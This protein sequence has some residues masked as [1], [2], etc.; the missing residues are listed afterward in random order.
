MHEDH[1][2]EKIRALTEQD[3]SL[4]IA[5]CRCE[6]APGW[7]ASMGRHARLG[8]PAYLAATY[9]G[10]RAEVLT[11]WFAMYNQG[12]RTPREAAR[13]LDRPGDAAGQG[14]SADIL[15]ALDRFAS[16]EQTPQVIYGERCPAEV[17]RQAC[18]TSRAA[19]KR[20]EM[21]A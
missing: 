8:T 16:A 12:G 13:A 2:E 14:Y 5:R 20:M 19:L 3:L 18:A 11:T 7:F 4:R 15:A 9:G 10:L 17:A 21:N 6:L 1:H